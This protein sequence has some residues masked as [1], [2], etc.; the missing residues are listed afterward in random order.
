MENNSKRKRS[1]AKGLAIA[2][3]GGL[4]VSL[5]GAIAT[6]GPASADPIKVDANFNCTYPLIGAQPTPITIET[7]IPKSI[8][9]G[10]QTPPI[11]IKATAHLSATVTNGLR[12]VKATKLEGT[13]TSDEIV[14]VPE[15]PNLPVSIDVT[16]TPIDVPAAGQG[17]DLV[18]EG[19]APTLTFSKAGP[20]KISLTGLSQHID[21]KKADGTSVWAGGKDVACT[22]PDGPK[23]LTEFQITAIDVAVSGAVGDVAARARHGR[24]IDVGGVQ[25]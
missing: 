4:G 2:A 20:G 16:M 3:I 7:D 19:D 23:V 24:R 13:A 15:D 17:F 25:L 12:A 14:S 9:V 21:P 6:A 18:T 10:Q 22:M 8:P 5:A 11:H 1:R